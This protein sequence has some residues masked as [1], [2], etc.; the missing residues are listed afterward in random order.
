MSSS[1]LHRATLTQPE[2]LE[3]ELRSEKRMENRGPL[4]NRDGHSGRLHLCVYFTIYSLLDLGDFL[5]EHG[6]LLHQVVNSPEHWRHRDTQLMMSD[7]QEF[8]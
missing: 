8:K 4:E 5:V 3:V 2:R 7:V 6:L 1:S